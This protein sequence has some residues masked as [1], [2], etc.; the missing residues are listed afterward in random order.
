MKPETA[1]LIITELLELIPVSFESVSVSPNS[2]GTGFD[3]KIASN[4]LANLGADRDEVYLAF[5]TLLRRIFNKNDA[6]GQ[7]SFK[8]TIDI[9]DYQS[10]KNALLVTQAINHADE[11][12]LTKVPFDLPTMTSYERMLVHNALASVPGITTESVGL[13][14]ERHIRIAC[15]E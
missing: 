7:E 8:C 12:R 5:S 9:N 1:R 2:Q 11:V 14:R 10:R 6:P 15:K 13:G 4:D 3:V